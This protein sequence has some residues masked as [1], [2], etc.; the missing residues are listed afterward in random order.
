MEIWAWLNN[1]LLKMQW[2]SDLVK[3]LVEDGFGLSM[4]SPWGAQAL[5]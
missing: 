5:C 3:L 4:Q 1:Q 2:L